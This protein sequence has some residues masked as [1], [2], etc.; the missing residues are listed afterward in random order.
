MHNILL[1]KKSLL[2]AF[3]A[4]D[5]DFNHIRMRKR[6]KRKIRTFRY[7]NMHASYLP[8]DAAATYW[9]AIGMSLLLE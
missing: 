8:L 4:A 2:T 9:H 6:L 3:S 7:I 1:H 5:R